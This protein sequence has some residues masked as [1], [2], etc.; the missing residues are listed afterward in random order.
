MSSERYFRINTPKI[1]S[2]TIEGEVIII[3][4][5]SG[6]YYSSDDLGCEV[7][8][9]IEQRHSIEDILT[10]INNRYTSNT[11]D[12]NDTVQAFISELQQEQLIVP[13]PDGSTSVADLSESSPKQAVSAPPKLNKFKDM[14][15]LLLLDPVHDVDSAGWP[16]VK[17]EEK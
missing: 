2:E 12:L 11:F 9:L 7:W 10:T 14:Q 15:E 17:P 5:D 16:R 3:N 4:F 8:S 13:T 1:V 6:N